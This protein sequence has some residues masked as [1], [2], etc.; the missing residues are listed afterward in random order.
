MQAFTDVQPEHW[1]E[2]ALASRADIL[3]VLRRLAEQERPLRLFDATAP[4]APLATLRLLEADDTALLLQGAPDKAAAL[5]ALDEVICDTTLDNIRILF[6]AAGLHEVR[7]DGAAAFR[8]ALPQSLIRL[9]RRAYYRMPAPSAKPLHALI[10]RAGGKLAVLLHDISCGGIAL[11]DD[12][13]ALGSAIGQVYPD[14]EIALPEIGTVTASL[15]V[16]NCNEAPDQDRATRRL[17]CE[18]LDMSR[19]AMA[20]V[21]RYILN[22]ERT[23]NARLAGLA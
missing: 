6:G 20:A 10:P 15:Q 17:G 18:F 7:V 19:A 14:C 22:L 23:R 16:R 9:Q 21:Q 5:L 3:S 11:R 12:A 2:F 8:A 1:Q 4:A 13:R